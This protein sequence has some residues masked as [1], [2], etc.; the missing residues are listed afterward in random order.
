[1]RGLIL[2]SDTKNQGRYKEKH[3]LITCSLAA[4]VRLLRFS[5][6]RR[7]SPSDLRVNYVVVYL[8]AS[9]TPL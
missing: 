1:M 2:S 8:S 4:F 9:E 6:Q 3:R 5:F 7:S